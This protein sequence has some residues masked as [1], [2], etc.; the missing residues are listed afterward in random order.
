MAQIITV[1]PMYHYFVI[2][3]GLRGGIQTLNWWKFPNTGEGRYCDVE[4]KRRERWAVFSVG[5]QSFCVAS[6]EKRWWRYVVSQRVQIYCCE[7]VE[8]ICYKSNQNTPKNVLIGMYRNVGRTSIG[9]ATSDVGRRFIY[10]GIT[11]ISTLVMQ[12]NNWVVF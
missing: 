10:M 8:P 1:L 6:F 4:W 11:K 7:A 9:V 12:T 5:Q 2:T 3:L